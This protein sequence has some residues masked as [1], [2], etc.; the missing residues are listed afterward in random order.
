MR[1]FR[2]GFFQRVYS[3]LQSPHACLKVRL[4]KEKISQ[5]SSNVQIPLFSP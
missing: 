2:R 5:D 4:A 1:M 3:R